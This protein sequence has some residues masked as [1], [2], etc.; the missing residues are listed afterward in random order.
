MDSPTD[1]TS[2][3]E[4]D[5]EVTPTATG[6]Q[7]S[8]LPAFP[9]EDT[10]SIRRAAGQVLYFNPA[11]TNSPPDS[12]MLN[13]EDGISSIAAT[14]PPPWDIEYVAPP[15]PKSPEDPYCRE[16]P[17][18]KTPPKYSLECDEDCV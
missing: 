9:A 4:Y 16:S 8:P 3:V 11:F 14:S 10:A 6:R 13:Y 1:W 12:P 17:I 15:R 7:Q 18:L 5:G 2:D